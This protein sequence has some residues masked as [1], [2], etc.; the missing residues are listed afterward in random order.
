MASEQTPVARGAV[1]QDERELRS[2]REQCA[3]RDAA[4][5][6]SHG[7]LVA[8]VDSAHR[9]LYA[10]A[11]W[12]D[13]FDESPADSVGLPLL[14]II[15]RGHLVAGGSH[16]VEGVQEALRSGPDV[17]IPLR[18]HSHEHG[19][20]R[21]EGRAYSQRESCFLVF[22]DVSDRNGA[23][24]GSDESEDRLRTEK[25][26]TLG[27]LA[28]GVAHDFSNLLTP[29]VGNAS[30]LLADLP[31]GAPE[32]R[33][34]EG[35]RRAADRA[36][37]LTSQM[38]AHAGS[39]DRSIAMLDV[40]QVV[41]DITLLLETTASKKCRIRWDLA[42]GLPRIHGDAS[43]IGQ[44]VVSLVASASNALGDSGGT[45]DVR[46]GKIQASRQTLDACRLGHSLTPGEYVFLEVCDEASREGAPAARER[47]PGLS[48]VLGAVRAHEGAVHVDAPGAGDASLGDGTAYRVLLPVA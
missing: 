32:R 6:E 10:S 36:T 19:W 23:P 29:I 26:E 12:R 25:L 44:I 38:L 8:V 11:L 15:S 18:Y 43:Q 5:F 28:S 33:W 24:R 35:I 46:T 39:R 22:H 7:G 47:G 42:D 31:P 17:L 21:L 27:I 30:L 3:A 2:T 37:A 40:S 14:D 9:L 48:V 41:R 4:A 16:F 34:A 1:L 20:R 13:I 45:I